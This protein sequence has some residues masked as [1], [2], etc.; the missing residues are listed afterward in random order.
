MK[1]AL[2][3]FINSVTDQEEGVEGNPLVPLQNWFLFAPCGTIQMHTS[4]FRLPEAPSEDGA[5]AAAPDPLTG[6]YLHVTQ[7]I[8]D[9]LLTVAS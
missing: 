4:G 6:L 5:E 8:G 9:T 3:L 2:L 1:P 7:N